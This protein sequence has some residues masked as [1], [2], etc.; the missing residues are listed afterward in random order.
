MNAI[1]I[2]GA[3]GLMLAAL[4]ILA[5]DEA[6][7]PDLPVYS[8]NS[9]AV[10]GGEGRAAVPV[11]RYRNQVTLFTY[12]MF[13][14]VTVGVMV[15]KWIV[16]AIGERVAEAL[17]SHPD[18]AEPTALGKAAGLVAQ[19]EYG[20]ALAAYRKILEETP[21]ERMA[22]TEMVRIHHDR[23]GDTDGA[24]AVLEEALAGRWPADDRSFLM[25]RLA[26]LE[27]T[28]RRNPERARELLHRV[29][30]EFPGS[31]HAA[32]AGHR[33]REIDEAEFLSRG[34]QPS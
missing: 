18:S 9:A 2:R 23:L 4:V 31:R 24:V 30:S 16:P 15:L 6:K 14:A 17:Y 12:L 8:E 7:K 22:V 34:R 33:L 3:V 5:V 19:G 26:D 21:G 13:I 10:A 20:K 25:M 1:L 32:N 11:G 27:A 29:Q 28:G